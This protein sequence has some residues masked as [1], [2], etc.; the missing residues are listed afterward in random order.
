MQVTVEATWSGGERYG[1]RLTLP[2]GRRANLRGDTW[3]LKT[4]SEA[5]DLLCVEFRGIPRSQIRFK[6]K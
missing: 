4:A 1:F 5:L 3:N 6:V 2:D